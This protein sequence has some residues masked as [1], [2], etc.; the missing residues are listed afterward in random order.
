MLAA[1]SLSTILTRQTMRA[2]APLATIC[3]LAA[4]NGGSAPTDAN[5]G[6]AVTGDAPGDGEAGT[7]LTADQQAAVD[8]VNAARQDINDH[9]L[10][11]APGPHSAPLG[12]VTWSSSIAALA[13]AWANTIIMD[14]GCTYRHAGYNNPNNPGNLGENIYS[15][16]GSDVGIYARSTQAFIDE[17]MFYVFQWTGPFVN[18]SDGPMEPMPFD[19]QLADSTPNDPSLP[20][21]QGHEI[22]HYTVIIWRDMSQFGCATASKPGCVQTVCRYGP[23]M[24][25][26]TLGVAPY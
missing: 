21:N 25:I 2:L 19:A 1:R 10:Y 26:N 9:H 22:G 12:M 18:P 3:A 6:D 20:E 14:S 13:Q 5:N 15:W 7:M 23:N 17:R 4:C 8:L 24:G 16:T 11:P